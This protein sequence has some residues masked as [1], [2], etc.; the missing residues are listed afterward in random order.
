MG[1]GPILVT[2]SPRSG[3]T[4]V[5][6]IL[7]FAP[8]T[9]YVHE[10]FNR[11]KRPGVVRAAMP[12]N[13]VYITAE[14][15]DAHVASLADTLGWR[16]ALGPAVR[17]LRNP[18]DAARTAR[19]LAYFETMRRRGARLIMK[20]P[21]ALFS[22]AWLSDRFDMPVVVV[23]RHPAAFV[24]SM[25][26][27]GWSGNRVGL[28]LNQESLIRD[29]LAPF[30]AEIAAAAA[31][32]DRFDTTV[33]MWRLF[34][35]HIRL[36]RRERP[37]WIFVRHEDLSRDPVEGFRDVFARLGLDFDARA[38]AKVRAYSEGDKPSWGTL[39]L[40]GTRRRTVR[41]SR[42]NIAAFKRRLDAAQIDRIRTLAQDVW[43][44]FYADS[45]W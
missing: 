41:D 14:N 32:P 42:D 40:F 24:A 3:S 7:G 17:G 44:D 35:H 26:A 1:R 23:I 36:L 25:L 30:R 8:G 10:P 37:D 21:I 31:A 11:A 27:A 22:A 29:R 19:D 43:P 2:G 33:L 4:W 15:E 34:H 18:R 45:E 6:N 20:D 38:E 5:G 16:Y 28:L 12:M 13:Y 39:S 9:G